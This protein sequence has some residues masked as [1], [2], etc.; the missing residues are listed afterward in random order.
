M[1][2]ELRPQRAN[3]SGRE[4]AFIQWNAASHA[5][6]KLTSRSDRSSAAVAR[7]SSRPLT[8]AVPRVNK[9]S[10]RDHERI[11][12]RF[13]FIVVVFRRRVFLSRKKARQGRI[14]ARYQSRI[15]APLSLSLGLRARIKSAHEMI[16][17]LAIVRASFSPVPSRRCIR[18]PV[19]HA[20]GTR[21]G[22]EGEA[23]DVALFTPGVGPSRR[24][25]EK[26]RTM[27]CP[28][29]LFIV[30][31]TSRRAARTALRALLI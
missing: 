4:G 22:T 18:P 8:S 25:R 3:R 13:F 16:I 11:C 21:A 31:I 15:P 20:R 2:I 24:R 6:L 27:E 12:T 14:L 10:A 7:H 23:E 28:V 29:C 30:I 17:C 5:G 26:K 1:L 9:P 19:M